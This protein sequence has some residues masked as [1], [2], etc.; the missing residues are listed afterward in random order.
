MERSDQE[1]IT[2]TADGDRAA[3]ALLVRRYTA[4]LYRF[5]L[6]K[7]GDQQLAEDAVQEVLLRLY[8]NA[9]NGGGVKQPGP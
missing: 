4:S 7:L 8:R 3:F 2:A 1:L 6:G 5:C 9:T